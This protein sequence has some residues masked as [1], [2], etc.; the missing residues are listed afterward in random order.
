MSNS[1]IIVEYRTQNKYCP[2]C[3]QKLEKA[4]VSKAKTMEFSKETALSWAEWKEISEYPEDMENLVPEYVHE[5]I[6]FFATDSHEKIIVED[7]E[8]EK[9]KTWILSEVVT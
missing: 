2:C 6:S 8:I 3:Q 9:V 5:T 7:S 4:K 1:T